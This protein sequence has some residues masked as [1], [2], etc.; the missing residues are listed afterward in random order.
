VQD[1]PEGLPLQAAFQSSEPS[2]SIYRAFHYLHSRV[3]LDLQE[4]L[5]TLES[6]LVDL[7]KIDLENG[8]GKRLR[9]R[10]ADL[11]QA[12]KEKTESR[13]QLL[14]RIRCKLVNYGTFILVLARFERG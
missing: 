13:S 12:K 7:D 5:R 4:E 2:W 1:Y 14:G 8:D 11:Q 3:I 6:E 10:K 9:S